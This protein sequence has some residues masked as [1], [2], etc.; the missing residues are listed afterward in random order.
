MMRLNSH[1][2]PDPRLL[3]V[4]ITEADIQANQKW[5]FSDEILAQ[6]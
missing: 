1:N 3:I 4:E 5:P 2:I 6:A